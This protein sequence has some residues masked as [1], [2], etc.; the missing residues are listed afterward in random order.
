MD[1]LTSLGRRSAKQSLCALLIYLHDRVSVP[2]E[3]GIHSFELP[4]T[5]DQIGDVLGLH[6]VHVNRMFR[7]LENDGLILRRPKHI[8]LLDP[9][10]LRRMTGLPKR[11]LARNVPWLPEAPH[12]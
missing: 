6:L 7:V 3:A 10:E 4:L 5:Q 2:D 9:D 11:R 12:E 1:R 8:T